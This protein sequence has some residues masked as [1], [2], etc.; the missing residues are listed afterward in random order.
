MAQEKEENKPSQ[1]G[2]LEQRNSLAGCQF[3]SQSPE[4]QESSIISRGDEIMTQPGRSGGRIGRI[5]L[6]QRP[7]KSH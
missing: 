2:N 5:P 1:T 7:R 4:P 3:L 6:T